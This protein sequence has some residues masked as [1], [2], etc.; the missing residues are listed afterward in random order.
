MK[1]SLFGLAACLMAVAVVAGPLVGDASAHGRR[2]VGEH[3]WTVGWADEP[4]FVGF[5]NGVQLFLSLGTDGPPVEGAEKDLKVVVSIGDRET[6]PLELRTVF[7]SPG[8][9]RADLIPTVPGDYTFRFTGTID[10][11]RVD[12]SWT[13]SKDDFSE[14]EGT[15]EVTF[16]KAAPSNAELAERLEAVESTANN[17]EDA[18]VLP[19]TI[20]IV[21]V[22]LGLIALVVAARPKRSTA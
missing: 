11:E 13:G 3:E 8:E 6:D 14:I 7:D 4:A 17:A 20:A 15:S 2:E 22:I 10:G 18:V 21:G 1:R 12:E 16:P 9:Y 5:K 19:R